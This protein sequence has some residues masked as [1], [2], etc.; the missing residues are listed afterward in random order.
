MKILAVG[1]A[2]NEE[3]YLPEMARYYREQGCD[4]LILDN[5]STDG[6]YQWLLDNGIKTGRVDTLK[7]FHLDKLQRAME[8]E[9]EKYDPDWVVY[10]G[11]DIYYSFDK[12]I[13]KTIEQAD[14]MGHNIIQVNNWSM[15][16]TGEERNG[17]A[18]DIYFYGTKGRGLRMIAK[19]V[20]PFSLCADEIIIPYPSVFYEN[21]ILVNYGNTK[22]KEEREETFA[23]R[24]R[25]WDMGLTKGWGSHYPVGSAKGWIWDKYELTD[26]MTTDH[27]KYFLK[28]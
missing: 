25:A 18:K 11:I 2:Y 16:N 26:V 27:S 14:F 20:K 6:T 22:P 3:K 28:I 8:A 10:V 5:Y 21:G 24:K 1:T 19:Y 12:T 4:I 23:R 13:R 17:L 7:A 9:I 15:Y